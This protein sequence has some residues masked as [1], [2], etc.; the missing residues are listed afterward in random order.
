VSVELWLSTRPVP[1]MRSAVTLEQQGWDGVAFT[2][3]QNRSGD[4]YVALTAAALTTSR[5]K[6]AIGVTNPV[7]RHPVVTAAG[8]ASVQLE[9]AGRA[10]LGIGRGDSALAYLGLKPAGVP[11][12]RDYL[13]AVQAYLSG[14]GLAMDLARHGSTDAVDATL[15]LADLP[16]RSTLNWLRPEDEAPKVPV[17]VAASGPRV[18]RTA[19]ELADRVMLAVGADPRRVRW[20][21]EQARAV[22]PDVPIGA[23][24]NVVVHPR[25]ESAAKMAAGRVAT[26]ARFSAMHGAVVGPSS[27][28]HEAVFGAVTEAF[29]MT[30]HG[31]GGTHVLQLTPDFEERFAILGPAGYC[32]DRLLELAELGIDRFHVIGPMPQF[33]RLARR[34]FVDQVMP[35]LRDQVPPKLP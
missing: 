2:E 21:I 27:P 23:F 35:K 20:A 6:L 17:F 10:E 4:P 28:E 12:L 29:Q 9:A 25:R 24:V 30:K 19:A 16:E 7:T 18:I 31:L 3:S 11:A 5:I 13:V 22:R 1:R 14:A 8:I 32:L 15:P 34:W 26:F 33:E